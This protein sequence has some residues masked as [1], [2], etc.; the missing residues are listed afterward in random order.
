MFQC[1]RPERGSLI[2][3]CSGGVRVTAVATDAEG[4]QCAGADADG[5]YC[6]IPVCPSWHTTAIGM[7]VYDALVHSQLIE[8]C[9]VGI[10]Y[11]LQYYVIHT[12]CMPVACICL[13]TMT[14]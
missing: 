10:A 14:K 4:L 3:I 11:V 9:T 13:E 5:L 8:H 6:A 7:L 12:V 2:V 1:S